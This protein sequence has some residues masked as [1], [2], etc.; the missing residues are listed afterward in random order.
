MGR[1]KE[2][3]TE[4]EGVGRKKEEEEQGWDRESGRELGKG[5]KT[6]RSTEER[7]EGKGR[8]EKEE[9]IERKDTIK[10]REEGTGNR[11]VHDGKDKMKATKKEKTDNTA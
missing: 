4:K 8:E 9:E 3:E 11:K 5:G 7:R 6:G 10:T 1:R 2:E